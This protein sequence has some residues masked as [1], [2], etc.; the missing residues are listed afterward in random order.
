VEFLS[1]FLPII[2]Y[3]LLII[4]IVVGIVLGIKL[5]ITVDKVLNLVDDVQ[6]KVNKVT[7]IF[8]AFGFVSDKMSGVITTVIGTIEN[9]IS[10]LL[11]KRKRNEKMEDEEDE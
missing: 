1:Q 2:I 9:L 10:N 4:I 5:I 6:E 3:I 7:P 11:L 8:N